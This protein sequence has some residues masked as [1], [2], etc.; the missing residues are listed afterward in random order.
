M[1]E[2]RNYNVIYEIEVDRVYKD[3]Q[4][5]PLRKKQLVRILAPPP[6]RHF[7]MCS[8]SAMR[9]KRLYLFAIQNSD[10]MTACDWVEEYRSLSKSQKQGIK[11]AYARSCDQ[12]QIY[13]SPSGMLQNHHEWDNNST[14]VAEMDQMMIFY[15]DYMRSDCYAT[16]SHCAD[17]KGECKWYSSKEFKKCKNKDKSERRADAETEEK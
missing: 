14:C 4:R 2:P 11:S 5:L 16:Y 1:M 7:P 10:M 15:P 3:S 9:R 6:Q 13:I 17:R 12:C 8:Y